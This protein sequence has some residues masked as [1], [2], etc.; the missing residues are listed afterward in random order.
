MNY[1]IKA[2]WE[3]MY[4]S[5]ELKQLEGYGYSI[6][7]KYAYVFER[8]ETLFKEYVEKYFEKKS[9]STGVFKQLYKLLLNS[10]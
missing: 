3:G 1:L 2:K 10:L 8:S 9:N 7:V 6:R 5:E 4:F